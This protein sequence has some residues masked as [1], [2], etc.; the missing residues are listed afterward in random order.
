MQMG[1]G[2]VPALSEPDFLEKILLQPIFAFEL[3][4]EFAPLYERRRIYRG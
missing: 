4:G 3:K 1:A 2:I